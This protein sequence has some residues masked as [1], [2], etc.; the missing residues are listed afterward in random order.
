[1]GLVLER[2][3]VRIRPFGAFVALEP[4]VDGL[5]HI[6]QVALTRVNKVEDVLT[7]GQD[8]TVEVLGVDPEAKRIS[9]SIRKVL[10]DNAFEYE[11]IEGDEFA[12]EEVPAEDTEA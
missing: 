10:E 2:K 12:A 9:L 6:S 1:M 4:G 3:V 5:V 7:V 11:G 8:V